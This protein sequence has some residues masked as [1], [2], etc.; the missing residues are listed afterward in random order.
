MED[1]RIIKA[2]FKECSISDRKLFSQSHCIMPISIGQQVH[3]GKKFLATIHLVNRSFKKCTLLIDDIIQRYTLALFNDSTPDQMYEHSLSEGSQW[4][5]RNKSSYSQLTIPFNIIRWDDWLKDPD[6][7]NAYQNIKCLYSQEK[8]FKDSVDLNINEFLSRYQ[9]REK[10]STI[11]QQRS[12]Y[13]CLDYLFEECAV[14]CLWPKGGYEFEVYP[15]GRNKA[16]AATY[17]KVI[18]PQY[19]HL[20]KSVALR[21]K[22][23][24]NFLMLEKG[25]S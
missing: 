5:E 4:L 19:P 2:S 20:L 17:T 7:Q 25:I 11:D 1:N 13:L 12:F 9:D 16:M 14:M 10:T 23:Y 8:Y 21:F 24:E 22:K 15:T 6:F 18:Q 3:E